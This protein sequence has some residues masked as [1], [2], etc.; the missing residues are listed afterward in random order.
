MTRSTRYTGIRTVLAGFRQRELTLLPAIIL[1]LV[2]GAFV[3]PAFLT[4][5]NF[6][7]IFQ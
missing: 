3:N 6:L 4:I 1:A 7:N 5:D 2:V